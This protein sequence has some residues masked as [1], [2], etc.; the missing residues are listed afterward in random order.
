MLKSSVWPVDRTL[1][2]A[3]TPGKSGPGSNGNESALRILQS[4]SITEASQSDCLLSYL[5]HSLGEACL[6]AVMQSVFSAASANR[7]NAIRCLVGLIPL[8]KV[9][10][11]ER[12]SYGL[13]STTCV[14]LQRWLWHL[15]TH[16][17][18]YTIKQRRPAIGYIVPLQ[19]FFKDGFGIK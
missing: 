13:N 6:S 16:E 8:G 14:L 1:S 2:H 18:W 19:F 9:E 3:T 11:A 5:G 10:H 4:S 7:A 12:R 15:I 17:G